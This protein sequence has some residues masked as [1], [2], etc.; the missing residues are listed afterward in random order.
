VYALYFPHS[1]YIS[2]YIQLIAITTHG[3]FIPCVV[4]TFICFS[5]Y[6]HLSVLVFLCLALLFPCSLFSFVH[7]SLANTESHDRCLRAVRVQTWPSD[8]KPSLNRLYKIVFRQMYTLYYLL[9]NTVYIKNSPTCF[10]LCYSSSSGTQL[11]ITPAIHV[12]YSLCT[13][14]TIRV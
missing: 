9:F 6:V 14:S 3:V 8:Q 10:E 13:M 5:V 4:I 12:W 2:S 11:F 7:F 1:M